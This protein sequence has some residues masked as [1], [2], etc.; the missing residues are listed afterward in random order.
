MIRSRDRLRVEYRTYQ[1]RPC[2]RCGFK[3]K[4]VRV[5]YIEGIAVYLKRCEACRADDEV[6]A[7]IYRLA[8]ARRH[9]KQL[10]EKQDQQVKEAK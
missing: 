10:R 8:V 5:E 6:K 9:A 4:R 1:A 7:R 2:T 3:R